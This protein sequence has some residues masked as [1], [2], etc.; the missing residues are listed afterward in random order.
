MFVREQEYCKG[1][2]FVGVFLVQ[3]VMERARCLLELVFRVVVGV[4]EN[5]SGCRIAG[6][7]EIGFLRLLQIALRLADLGFGGADHCLAF[8]EVVRRLG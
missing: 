5:E 8:R 7:D 3:L 4:K 6:C 2:P 1:A